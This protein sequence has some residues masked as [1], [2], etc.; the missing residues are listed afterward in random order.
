M[1]IA[2]LI[3]EF[4]QSVADSRRDRP[5]DAGAVG[6]RKGGFSSTGLVP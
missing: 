4:R 6:F 3:W 1:N 5:G 2:R